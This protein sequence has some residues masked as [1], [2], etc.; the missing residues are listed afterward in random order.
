MAQSGPRAFGS[1]IVSMSEQPSDLL[2]VLVLAREVGLEVVPVPLFETLGDLERAPQV[3]RE[4]LALPEYREA[5]G[6]RVQEV[7]IGYS[8][9]N[10]DAGFVAANW[11]LHEAQARVAEVCAKAGVQHRFFHGRGT[12]I[13]RGGGPMARGCSASPLARSAPAFASPSRVKR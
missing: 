2:E 3:M 13:G 12:S 10:K 8:D 6:E 1:Y 7:M 5:I 11:A 4:V 9:S